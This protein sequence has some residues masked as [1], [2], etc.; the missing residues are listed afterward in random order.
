MKPEPDVKNIFI[1]Q[2]QSNAILSTIGSLMNELK[3]KLVCSAEQNQILQ[4]F[5]DCNPGTN[6]KSS[7]IIL[8]GD[9]KH[10]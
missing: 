4:A 3:Y 6:S 10:S 5:A 7:F 9:K 8:P 1:I 2:E